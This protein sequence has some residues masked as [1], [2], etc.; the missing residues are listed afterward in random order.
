[1][2]RLLL[3]T[4][5]LYILF[6]VGVFF[7]PAIV[8]STPLHAGDITLHIGETKQVQI[9]SVYENIQRQYG[10]QSYYWTSSGGCF[11]KVSQTTF[12]C[13]IQ[14]T[15][16]G[17]GRLEY[18]A[19]MFID[20]YYRTHEFY[21]DITVL[22][23]T[24]QDLSVTPHDLELYEGDGYQ[25]HV[26]KTPSDAEVNLFWDTN[27]SYVAN[28]SSNGYVTANH[29][30]STSVYVTDT[31]SGKRGYC[32]VT[33]KSRQ[34]QY[35]S[36]SP[37][38][39]QL[40]WNGSQYFTARLTP[41]NADVSLSWKSSDE[42][43]AEVNQQGRVTAKQ[44]NGTTT[45]TVTDAKTGKKA[46]AEVTVQK[47]VPSS[48]SI[49]PPSV[50]LPVGDSRKLSCSVSPTDAIYTVSWESDK[51]TI[52]QVDQSGNVT[53]KAKG[54]AKIMVRTDNGKTATCE[55][56]VPPQPS[57]ISV[58]PTQI[59]LLMGRSAELSYEIK[60]SDA[61]ART[62]TWSSSD[63]GIASVS[64][65]GKVRANKPGQT[66]I[67]VETDNGKKATCQ[68]TVP[69]PVFQLFVW[70]KNG[71]KTGYISTDRPVFT[72]NGDK[73]HLM[74]SNVDMYIQPEQ[75]DRFTLEQ[76]LPE[77][78]LAIDVAEAITIGLGQE[79]QLR[80]QLTPKDAETTVTWLNAA[81]DVVSIS[82]SGMA[83]GLKVGT[84][85]VKAQTA[86]GLRAECVITVPQPDLRFFV[87]LRDGSHFGYPI[88]E[89]PQVEL[90][91][92][93]FTLNSTKTKVE[94]PSDQVVKFTLEDAAAMITTA[95][96][97]QEWHQAELHLQH[98]DATIS[99]TKP[100]SK[101]RIVDMAG[102]LVDVVTADGEGFAVIPM[103]GYA[104]G[105]YII[106]T[107]SITYK[108][109]KK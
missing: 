100:G 58:K 57:S 11:S 97:Q 52:A 39:M 93:K 95:I 28:V 69:M 79:R 5:F 27:D 61:V 13:T 85:N 31:K 66:T 84:A 48:V 72:F 25:L 38:S 83:K 54:K 8:L 12:T 19:S 75:F 67:T 96:N 14:A 98:G 74:T 55:V 26:S 36:L 4:R 32:Y 77:Q 40:N 53:A 49:S 16:S 59:E 109:Q 3:N 78:P 89:K 35:I 60:P 104:N 34:L 46:T 15:S 42:M 65:D 41:E 10:T 1:M 76:V 18:F 17:T 2:R 106:K 9:G 73:I 33:V 37:S 103:S 44:K 81:P 56:T 30:G 21:W 91:A 51:P 108:I 22:D 70:M 29:P 99:Q 7:H 23:N 71:E 90:G 94:F 47:V 62:I 68:V 82:P 50:T 102:R 20:G 105:I 43:V 107:E 101:V 24:L 80:Y 86:N 87:W 64:Q 63:Y 45:I 88:D 6:L 92:E